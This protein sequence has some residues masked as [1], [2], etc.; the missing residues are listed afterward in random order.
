MP[1]PIIAAL[2]YDAGT[3]G[4]ADLLLADT[5]RTLSARGYRLAGA[6]QHNTNGA[7]GCLCDMTLEDLSSGRLVLISETRGPLARGC[8]LDQSALEDVVGLA[9]TA[10]ENGAD[11]LVVN[12]FGKREVEGH[13]L[14]QVIEAAAGRGIPILAAVSATNLPAWTEFTGGIDTRLPLDRAH[15]AAWCDDVLTHRPARAIV[16]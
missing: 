14:R 12:K 10:I 4:A 9:G 13:G 8:R 3:G 11:L 2:V 16:R 6:I 7:D 15:L 5:T 1:Q